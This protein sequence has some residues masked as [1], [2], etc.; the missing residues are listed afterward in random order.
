VQ[1]ARLLVL[2]VQ[3]R[4]ELVTREELRSE[5]WPGDTFGDF[6]HGLNNAVNRLREALGDSA[7]SPRY[8][9]T[10][11]RR[12]YRFIAEVSAE[13]T[14]ST[15]TQ[16]SENESEP[17]PVQITGASASIGLSRRTFLWA[18]AAFASI[19]SVAWFAGRRRRLPAA[20][21]VAV[22]LVDGAMAADVGQLLG[23]PV[24]AP[25]GSEIVV[26]LST[27]DGAYL[28]RRPL[29]SNHMIRMEGTQ[30]ASLPFWSPDSHHIGFFAD[31][32]LKR[33]P[34]FGGSFVILCDVVEPRGGCW[35]GDTI[36]FAPN[37]RG[38]FQI[39]ATGGTAVPVTVLD[40][41]A[42][43]NSHRFPVFLP[44]GNRFLYFSRSSSLGKRGI[45][46]ES[47]DH[48]QPRRRVLVA[49]GQFA[50]GAIPDSSQHFLITQQAS[51]LVA[52]GFDCDSGKVFGA[53]HILLDH[54]GQVS[55]SDTG[56]LAL[57][58]DAQVRST[59]VW[60]DR[61]GRHLGILGKPDDYWQAAISPDGRFVAIVRH[62]ALT[63]IFRAWTACLANGQMEV[64]S[65]ADH[66]DSVA[67]T[68]DGKMLYYIDFVQRKLFR[69][70]VDPRGPEEFVQS[71]A[72]GDNICGLSPDG[73][74]VIVE[75]SKD[76]I[77][78]VIE[79]SAISP[80]QWH[81]IDS[82]GFVGNTG[83]SPDGR[84]LAFGSNSS[85]RMEVYL[86][87]FPSMKNLR[88]VSVD[89][90]SCPRWRQDSEELFYIAEDQS[91]MCLDAS[92]RNRGMR[93]KPLFRT[94]LANATRS[95]LY[96]VASDG[97]R[98]LL[99]ER[100]SSISESDVELLLN[101]PSLLSD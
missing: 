72:N 18:A 85:G 48:R 56:A 13:G 92:E 22:P 16:P 37:L 29:K 8:I 82:N 7:A 20:M 43:E 36:L 21:S 96:D 24:I 5:L 53:E 28:F 57:R 99:L 101:W 75:R 69:R 64:L 84:S 58:T 91:L 94:A 42:G 2:L 93:P 67:W 49:D 76:G 19:G 6:D 40:V 61:E 10:A 41:G 65:D 32:Q 23:A 1:P 87:G 47:L 14:L 52:Q 31:G 59:L 100:D 50:L 78:S 54:A 81:L 39:G 44:D 4:G 86:A 89:G 95:P 35:N 11:P 62:D 27:S 55:A 25:D 74:T 70:S 79:W 34:A 38:I 66:V 9:Q 33:T 3:R 83:L 26:S 88:R 60:R 97:S 15:E 80:L 77:H 90:G 51:K 45:Y 68:H 71:I 12:G 17:L 73:L 63:G 46:L 30:S 98:F